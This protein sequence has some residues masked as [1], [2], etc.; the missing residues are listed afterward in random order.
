MRD[1]LSETV[2]NDTLAES[3][4]VS[5]PGDVGTS[6]GAGF[7]RDPGLRGTSRSEQKPIT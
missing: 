1:E 3:L 5:V 2:A 6:V 7:R 4:Q